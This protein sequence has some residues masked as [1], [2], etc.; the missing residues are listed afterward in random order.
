MAI[1]KSFRELDV[2]RRAFETAVR[3]RDLSQLFPPHERYSLTDQVCRSARSV[4]ANIAEAWRKRRYVR[5]FTSKL[6]DADGEAA[7]TIVWL[8]FALRHGCIDEPTHESL[9]DAYDHIGAQLN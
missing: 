9:C 6:F 3:V 5:S 4:C 7:E 8:D 1:A 2:H